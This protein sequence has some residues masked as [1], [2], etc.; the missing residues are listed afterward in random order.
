M[1]KSATKIPVSAS[2]RKAPAS[3]VETIIGGMIIVAMMMAVV[4]AAAGET[5]I[6][7]MMFIG[8][9]VAYCALQIQRAR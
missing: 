9:V 2:Y 3:A 7:F 6:G 4:F 5:T 1:S 8:A